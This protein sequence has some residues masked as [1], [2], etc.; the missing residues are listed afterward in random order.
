MREPLAEEAKDRS[1]ALRGQSQ[2]VQ[3]QLLARLQCQEIGAF[4][5][6]VS[7]RKFAGSTFQRVDQILGEIEASL[8]NRAVR[9]KRRRISSKR[10]QRARNRGQGGID[11]GIGAKIIPRNCQYRSTPSWCRAR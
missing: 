10:N 8:Q 4:L 11:I 7:E 3:A 1:L 9:T 5:V 6:Q 2:G